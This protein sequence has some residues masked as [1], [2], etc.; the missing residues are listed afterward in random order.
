MY[1]TANCPELPHIYIRHKT[2]GIL[3]Q[4]WPFSFLAPLSFLG[5]VSI[6]CLV[7]PSHLVVHFETRFI[8]K[9]W[10]LEFLCFIATFSSIKLPNV[11]VSCIASYK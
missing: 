3:N 2:F 11:D 10:K 9:N 6:A 5:F 7:I 4:L 1:K 8:T